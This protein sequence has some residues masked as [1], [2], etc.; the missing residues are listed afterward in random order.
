MT[1]KWSVEKAN[2][3][4]S[5]L[6]PIRGCNYLPRTAVNTTEFWQANTFDPE[7]IKQELGWAQEAGYNSVRVF[8]QFLV[9]QDDPSGLKQRMEQFLSIADEHGISTA[10]T[11]F[12]DCAFA[13]KE[14]FLGPQ[15]DPIP[16]IHNS[17]W[18]PSPGLKRVTDE[19][20][21]PQL[22]AY[23][24]D[25]V[26]TFGS[27]SRVLIWDLYNEPGN[28]NMNE[29]SIPLVEAAFEWTRAAN[30]QQPV[31]SSVWNPD[32][33]YGNQMSE[34]LFELSD[35]VSFHYYLV[36]GLEQ[37]IERCQS[38]G[39]PVICTECL[40]R[41]F[42]QTFDTF[43]PAFSREKIGWYNWGLVAGRTQTYFDWRPDKNVGEL[44]IWQHDL[45][46][47][48]GAAYDE[49]EIEQIRS[50]KFE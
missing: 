41:R 22:E 4:Y 27:D 7:T 14:P 24:Q 10:L 34:R 29:N 5:N 40:H 12:D 46:H 21:W 1:E 33:G 26:S 2:E 37:A 36:E 16:G 50:F 39:R 3:W 6:E 48:D 43:L 11:L 28:S 47:T 15:D 17:G 45:F 32:A 49:Q 35:I 44:K 13:G 19:T 25:I 42:D 31:T 8:V 18:T 23:V 20:I 30:P 9:W 38:F